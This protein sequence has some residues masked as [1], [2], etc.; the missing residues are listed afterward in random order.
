MSSDRLHREMASPKNLPGRNVVNRQIVCLTAA[1]ELLLLCAG[2]ADFRHTKS[3]KVTGNAMA[4][5]V[6]FAAR[7]GGNGEESDS[8]TYYIKGNRM[9]VGRSDGEIQVVGASSKEFGE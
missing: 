7:V 2:R 4:G 8:S 6:K 9:R 3:T 5:L 1:G